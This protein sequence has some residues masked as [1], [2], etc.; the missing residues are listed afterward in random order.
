MLNKLIKKKRNKDQF[1]E[2]TTET[3]IQFRHFII[4]YRIIDPSKGSRN[5]FSNIRETMVW[6]ATQ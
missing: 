3:P 6:T 1:S 4:I 2:K 5:Y